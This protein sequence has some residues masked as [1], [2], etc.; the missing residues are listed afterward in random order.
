M[1]LVWFGLVWS[2]YQKLVQIFLQ[3]FKLWLNEVSARQDFLTSHEIPWDKA[4]KPKKSKI[5]G[6]IFP[7]QP[8]FE[9]LAIYQIRPNQTKPAQVVYYI[10]LSIVW[11]PTKKNFSFLGL[12]GAEIMGPEN[13]NFEKRQF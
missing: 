4:F 10:L 1:G 3:N 9:I 11:E 5:F 7:G 13:S 12:T 6:Y 2:G 8:F